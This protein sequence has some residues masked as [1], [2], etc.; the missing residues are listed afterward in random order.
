MTFPRRALAPG[1]V[2]LCLYLGPLRPDGRH[3]LVTVIQPVSLADE[4]TFDWEAEEDEVVCPGVKGENLVTRALREYRAACAGSTPR[5]RVTIDKRVPIAAGMGGGSSDAAQAL[6]ALGAVPDDPCA[7]EVAASLGSDVPALMHKRPTLVAGAGEDV[8]PLGSGTPVGRFVL[9]PLPARLS[10]GEVYAAA[11]RLGLA[12]PA[13]ELAV[14]HR[15]LQAA[16]DV[17]PALVHNDLQDAARSLCPLIDPA[18]E[19]VGGACEHALVSGSGPTVFGIC[20]D[21]AEATEAA[22]AL[23][24]EYPGA[25]AVSAR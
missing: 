24:Q 23:A 15:E 9:V 12:R 20:R 5:A 13:R 22:G 2:N 11:D 14:R 17:S 7:R 21:D 10:T 25:V 18:L 1:K 3:E 4:L 8:R 19:A 6:L 16:G